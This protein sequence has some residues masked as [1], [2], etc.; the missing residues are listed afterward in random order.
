MGFQSKIE[1]MY[2]GEGTIEFYHILKTE[3]M[4]GM[5]RVYAQVT[6]PVNCSIGYHIHSGDGE[7]VFII[8]G[9]GVMDDNHEREIELKPGVDFFTP[10]GRGHGITNTG[11]EPI[12]LM[13]LIVYT[14]K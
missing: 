14:Q 5:A 12:V 10:D 2:G 4:N 6:I 8:S 11:D 13:A 1:H 7:S 9:H 3:E